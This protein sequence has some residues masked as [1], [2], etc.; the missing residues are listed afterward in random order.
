ME[1]EKKKKGRHHNNIQRP[2]KNKELENI[3]PSDI[4]ADCWH[5]ALGKKSPDHVLAFFQLCLDS[6]LCTE[7]SFGGAGGNVC[8]KKKEA[9]CCLSTV[10]RT[11]SSQSVDVRDAAQLEWA[12]SSCYRTIESIL[13]FLRLLH[14]LSPFPAAA[15]IID[16]SRVCTAAAKRTCLL[17]AQPATES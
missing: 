7:E 6:L 10:K 9:A 8:K 13:F 16:C 17:F 11:L 14:T 4:C 1:I 2:R 5:S 15:H 12:S 3:T